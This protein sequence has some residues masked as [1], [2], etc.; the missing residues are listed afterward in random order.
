MSPTEH[1]TER[2]KQHG[3]RRIAA[4]P[5]DGEADRE[6]QP[7]SRITGE[8]HTV[9]TGLGKPKL[10]CQAQCLLDAYRFHTV[11]KSSHRKSGTVCVY[12][13]AHNAS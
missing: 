2:D 11:V 5:R 6:L 9:I 8:E 4:D 10:K 3:C 7:L 13:Y 12:K 1:C